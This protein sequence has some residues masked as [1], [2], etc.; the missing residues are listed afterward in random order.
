LGKLRKLSGREIRRILEDSEF[1]FVRQHGSHMM[2]RRNLDRGSITVSVPDHRTVR[3]G[4]LISIIVRSS[5]PRSLFE[6]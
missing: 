3:T 5:L 6:E 2:M 4:T 1:V